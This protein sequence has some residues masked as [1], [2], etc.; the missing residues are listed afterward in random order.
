MV[1]KVKAHTAMKL[2]Y[3]A[4]SCALAC[5]GI[6]LCHAATDL[7]QSKFTQ[8]VND[9]KV[10]EMPAKTQKAAVKNEIFKAPDILRTGAASRVELVAEDRTVTRIGANS[11]FSFDPA[12]RTLSLEQGNVL[13][14]APK[15]KGGGTIRTTSAAASVLGTTIIVSS[16]PDGGFKVLT[17]EGTTKV[18]LPNGD[19]VRLS[20]GQMVFVLPNNKGFSPVVTF[21]LEEQT[22]GSQLVN[23]FDDPLPSWDEIQLR[24]DKQNKLIFSGELDDTGLLVGN[25]ATDEG[26]EIVDAS[27]LQPHFDSLSHPRHVQRH[28]TPPI[29]FDY[30]IRGL[31]EDND[32]VTREKFDT[33][34]D[35]RNVLV[36]TTVA[37]MSPFA[38]RPDLRIKATGLMQFNDNSEHRTDF[39]T[40][41]SQPSG[42][43][44]YGVIEE[45]TLIANSFSFPD[46]FTVSFSGDEF[47]LE[48][49]H[50]LNIRSDAAAPDSVGHL[51]FTGGLA[52]QNPY[53]FGELN[54]SAPNDIT[55]NGRVAFIANELNFQ[56][57]HDLRMNGTTLATT[58]SQQQPAGYSTYLSLAAQHL[59]SLNGVHF[60]GY[61]NQINMSANTIVLQNIDFTSGSQVYLYSESG[62]LAPNPNTGA[63]V[64]P[65]DVNFI[66][67][68]NY[69]GSPA[70]NYV[71]YYIHLSPI[72]G[73]NN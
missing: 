49:L 42:K 25:T 22:K 55:I 30:I 3:T 33:F 54:V 7:K 61:W 72:N 47:N 43:T 51:P 21:N 60:V 53:I 67:N 36:D 26:I 18:K 19:W 59:I 63:A 23:G 5:A 38:D 57:G 9:V 15:G 8:V 10:L 45:L 71:G 62:N 44:P 64:V 29:E 35:A 1:G 73:K 37:D 65:G 32:H 66:R 24:I 50:D 39:K 56:A 27:A 20:A 4:L 58:F 2:S 13:F 52:F 28:Q 46:I 31:M 11:I 40:F 17:L 48:G 69:G 41:T 12:S 6:P 68:V 34:I 16:T 14:H 70:Q